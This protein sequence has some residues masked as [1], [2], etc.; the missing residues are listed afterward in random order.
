M[1]TIEAE[2]VLDTWLLKIWPTGGPKA[3]VL[4]QPT[5]RTSEKT[6]ELSLILYFHLC[7]LPP[8]GLRSS[9]FSTKTLYAP[10]LSPLHAIYRANFILLYLKTRIIFGKG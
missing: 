5:L 4:N 8:S 10:L 2:Q 7:L 3:T 1:A 9:E 6:A